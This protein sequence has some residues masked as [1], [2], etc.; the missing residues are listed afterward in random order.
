[1]REYIIS[2]SMHALGIPT[3]RS[4]AVVTTGKDVI[5]ETRLQGAILTRAASS[6][7]RVGTFQYAAQRGSIHDLQALADYT[8]QRHFP[9]IP[10]D[11]ER[12]RELLQEVIKR[13]AALIAKW[14]LAGFIH[15]VMNTDNMALSGETIDFGPCAFM[16]TY[17]PQTVF[18]SIDYYGR[19]AYANQ[20]SIAGW[21]LARFA[22][23]LLPLLHPEMPRAVNLAQEILGS[24][25]TL[26]Q[27]GW[28]KGMRRKLGLFNDESEDEILVNELLTLM[29]EHQ[30]DYTNT[31]R[32]LTLD[33]QQETLPGET[34]QYRQWVEKWKARLSR[35]PKSAAESQQ[36][37]RQSNP[38]VIPRNHQVEAS[39]EAA[40][41][42]DD[43]SVM[44]RLLAALE[45]PFA[46]TP[47]QDVYAAPPSPSDVP[48][49]TFCGT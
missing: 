6:H 2:E 19:Y 7:I 20:P 1:L 10:S 24:F 13:Q 29:Q 15:G 12:Y 17:H 33:L 3:T 40:V 37:M 23:T 41:N 28:L 21:N 22:E 27:H 48:Y 46:Y 34:A 32:S 16:D 36:L 35:Q 42:S 14:Q 39:L 31:F 8:L 18:S 5:R 43:F 49:R 44:R 11:D 45:N 47:D 38:A 4:L 9:G 26:Y 25:P 30:M